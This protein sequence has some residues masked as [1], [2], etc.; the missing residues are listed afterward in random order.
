MPHS[1]PS[2]RL[3]AVPRSLLTPLLVLSLGA[4]GGAPDETS[5]TV[6]TARAVRGALGE[7]APTLRRLA[8]G[9][10]LTITGDGVAWVELDSGPRVLVSTGAQLSVDGEG[11]LMVDG[12]RV[13]VEVAP[14]DALTVRFGTE[15]EGLELRL[16]DA[17][18]SLES[19]PQRNVYVVRGEVTAYSIQAG[20]P[21]RQIG[22]RK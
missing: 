11:V 20:S 4:C 2:S 21:L 10:A 18:V 7:G 13:Y 8:P 12:G 5:A 22:M 14:R 6:A 9:E 19:T 1:S 3:C 17:A 16:S 15:S